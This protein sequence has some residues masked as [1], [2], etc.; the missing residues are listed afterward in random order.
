MATG[1]TPQLVAEL[2][3]QRMGLKDGS[4]SQRIIMM[5]PE[6]LKRC[7]R[8]VAANPN[9]R[10][11]MFTDRTAATI[12]I[13]SGKVDLTT[14]YSTHRALQE[15]LDV[16]QIWHSSSAHPLQKVS[17]VAGSNL[18]TY[19][20]TNANFI[21]YYL[22]GK[23]LVLPGGETG[24]LEFAVPSYPAT[25]S[26]LPASNEVE[27]MFL[28]TVIEMLAGEKTDYTQEEVRGNDM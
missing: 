4:E 10:D 27:T 14:L 7:A 17:A 21:Y 18:A 2:V 19:M 22:Q 8:K 26:Q 20:G 1:L 9:L 3:R 24:S 13:A 11:L 28:D 25:V 6:A 5:I 16:G 23:Y 12:A 15:F